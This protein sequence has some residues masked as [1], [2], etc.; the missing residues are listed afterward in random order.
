[1]T[2]AYILDAVRTPRGKGRASGSLH[3][4]APAR[5]AGGLLEA[6]RE[7][8]GFTPDQ[9]ADVILGCGEPSLEQ[10]SNVARAAPFAAEGF[11]EVPGIQLNRFCGSGLEAC[12]F[13]AAMVMAG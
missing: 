7:R 4:V 1:M 9:V 12:N 8:N 2:E 13:A 10:A 6:L 5:L 11:R 3:E